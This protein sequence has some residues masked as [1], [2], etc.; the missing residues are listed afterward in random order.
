MSKHYLANLTWRCQNHCSYCWLTPS[1]RT[2]PEMMAAP[3]RPLDDWVRATRRDAVDTV[4]IAGGE[5]LLV[6]W[7]VEYIKACPDTGFGL[8]TNGRDLA[9]LER[10]VRARP[11]NVIAVN[12]SCHPETPGGQRQFAAAARLIAGAGARFHSN[13]VDAPGIAEQTQWAKALLD[14]LGMPYEVSPYERVE[15]L[16]ALTETGLC[17]KGGVNHLTIAPDGLAW[18]CLTTIRSPYWR[19]TCLGNWLDGPVT[20]EHKPQPCYLN[21]VDRNVLEKCHVAG[22]MWGVEARPCE[23]GA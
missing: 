10:L 1:V 21:C 5:P 14:E 22:D 12:L 7:L 19:E 11:R 6:P 20:L 17:C 23:E 4:D 9:A 16:G 13:V 3:E 8:S 15:D 2:R 18:P